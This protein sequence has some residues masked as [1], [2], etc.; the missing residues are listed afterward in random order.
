MVLV[1]LYWKFIRTTCECSQSSYWC[2]LQLE[3]VL[4]FLSM[5]VDVSLRQL[6]SC[7]LRRN[8]GRWFIRVF[9]FQFSPMA[10]GPQRY[11]VSTGAD[12]TVCFW[13]WDLESLKFRWVI[14][15]W[16]FLLCNVM[17]G[18]LNVFLLNFLLHV[19]S[20]PSL[21][22]TEMLKGLN[23]SPLCKKIQ[24]IDVDLKLREMES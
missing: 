17:T 22:Q 21:W 2:H 18:S 1:Y 9:D 5:L 23:S 7:K 16:W 4:Y 12:G 14:C 19:L 8:S 3:F 13:Q 11:M 15:M 10:K 24:V 6:L 20:L